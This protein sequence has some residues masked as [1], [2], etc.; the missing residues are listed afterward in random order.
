[1]S[2]EHKIK[3]GIPENHTL[4]STGSKSEQRKGKDTDY[5]FYNE[6]DEGGNVLAKYEVSEA[7]SIYPPFGTAV[8]WKKVL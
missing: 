6:V 2:E 4:V 3:M 5:Y 7:M 8:N 1:M